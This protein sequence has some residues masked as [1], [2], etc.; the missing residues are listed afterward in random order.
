MFYCILLSLLIIFLIY[1]LSRLT[2]RTLY[3]VPLLI[4][5]IILSKS[6][7][8]SYLKE[9]YTNTN[10]QYNL[11]SYFDPWWKVPA[12]TEEKARCRRN[13]DCLMRY[14]CQKGQCRRPKC[15]SHSYCRKRG[16][17]TCCKRNNLP[18]GQY[19]V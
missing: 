19:C 11:H 16:W 12:Y 14:I 17:E 3:I 9:S 10:Y 6:T 7:I 1:S 15:I 5:V 8:F 4:L 13:S 18:I 2:N